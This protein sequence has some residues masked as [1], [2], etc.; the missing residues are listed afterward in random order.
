MGVFKMFSSSCSDSSRTIIQEKIVYKQLPNP[1]PSNYKILRE[2]SI[3]KY[4]LIVVNYPDCKN[5]EGNKILLYEN[6]T[7]Q[8]LT[9]QKLVDPHFSDNAKFYSPIARFEPTEKGWKMALKF[10]ETN[11]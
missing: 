3:G 9:K 4:L 10:I 8:Q 6:V 1:D 5:Y 2:K 7:M 11:N